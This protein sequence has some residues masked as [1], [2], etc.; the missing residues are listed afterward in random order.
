MKCKYCGSINSCWYCGWCPNM[1]QV[2]NVGEESFIEHDC[3]D[4]LQ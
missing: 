3:K 1:K 2:N 4:I